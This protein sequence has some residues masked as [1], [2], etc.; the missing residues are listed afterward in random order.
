MTVY[1]GV[2]GPW[3]L[4]D[5]AAEAAVDHLSYVI[6]LPSV[7]WCVNR[8]ATRSGHAFK[9]EAS[10]RHMHGEFAQADMTPGMSWTA[11]PPQPMKQR[12]K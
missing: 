6:L 1:D 9:D 3:F 10:T 11:C 5:F 7:E 4:P 12:L 2:L 8:V